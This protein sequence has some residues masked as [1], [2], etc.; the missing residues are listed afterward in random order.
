MHFRFSGEIEGGVLL[1]DSV[2]HLFQPLILN[3]RKHIFEYFR[4]KRNYSIINQNKQGLEGNV[5]EKRKNIT[6]VKNNSISG[7]PVF[8]LPKIQRLGWKPDMTRMCCLQR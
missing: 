3:Y 1:S 5:F 7:K 8:V 2:C 6:I 4:E